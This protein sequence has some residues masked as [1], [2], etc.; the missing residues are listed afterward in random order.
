MAAVDAWMENHDRHHLLAT[1]HR[2]LGIPRRAVALVRPT[3]ALIKLQLHNLP[4][5]RVCCE[6]NL[7]LTYTW[8]VLLVLPGRFGGGVTP[9]KGRKCTEGDGP[10]NEGM[11]SVEER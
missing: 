10:C 5:D 1:P 3:R 11:R 2:L 6:H 9:P 7:V 8:Y 4:Q